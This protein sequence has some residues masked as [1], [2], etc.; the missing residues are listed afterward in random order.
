LYAEL[1]LAIIDNDVG[2]R[3]VS[4]CGKFGH[5]IYWY[6]IVEFGTGIVP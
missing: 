2:S 3:V 1:T 5:F 6:W 4:R